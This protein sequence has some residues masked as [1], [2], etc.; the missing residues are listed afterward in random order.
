[1]DAYMRPNLYALRSIAVQHSCSWL[2]WQGTLRHCVQTLELC[3]R[4]AELATGG[5]RSGL[6]SFAVTRL[7]FPIVVR[8]D[9]SLL[10]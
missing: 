10:K 3:K 7:C 8:A 5:L 2:P 9:G 1:M 6:Q 4:K